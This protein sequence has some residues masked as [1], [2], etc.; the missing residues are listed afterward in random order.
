MSI[1]G[2]LSPQMPN[3]S[4]RHPSRFQEKL[5]LTINITPSYSIT[6]CGAHTIGHPPILLGTRRG[7]YRTLVAQLESPV[8]VQQTYPQSSAMMPS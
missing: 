6:Q 2:P 3:K 4:I 1:E 7:S 8:T 5:R